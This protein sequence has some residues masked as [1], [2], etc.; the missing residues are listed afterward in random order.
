[1]HVPLQGA[2]GTDI[3]GARASGH[4]YA[5]LHIAVLCNLLLPFLILCVF[6]TLACATLDHCPLPAWIIPGCSPD[7]GALLCVNS[8]IICRKL[9][10]LVLS[11]ARCAV[12]TRLPLPACMTFNYNTPTVQGVIGC[13]KNHNAHISFAGSANRR[14]SARH[15]FYSLFLLPHSRSMTFLPG[16][17]R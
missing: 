4:F 14:S 8:S 3:V 11:F 12:F 15:A 2:D 5:G 17:L 16:V 7:G 10:F 9:F 1:M 13:I 6:A